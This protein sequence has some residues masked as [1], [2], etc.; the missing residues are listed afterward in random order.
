MDSQSIG[1][2]FTAKPARIGNADQIRPTRWCN[3]EEFGIRTELTIAVVVI[4]VVKHEDGQ[5]VGGQNHR[6]EGKREC[7]DG[8]LPLDHLQRGAR[9]GP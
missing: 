9:F 4:R 5:A 2:P 7:K 1:K 3:K 6:R 8:V